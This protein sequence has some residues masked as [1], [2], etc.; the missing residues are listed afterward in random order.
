MYALTCAEVHIPEC[1]C[2]NSHIGI[3]T[4]DPA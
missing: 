4:Y 2:I 3:G 1:F